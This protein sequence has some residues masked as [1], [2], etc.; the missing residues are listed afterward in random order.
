MAVV[1]AFSLLRIWILHVFLSHK[2]LC[3]TTCSIRL[4]QALEQN[5]VEACV[6]CDTEERN[7][8]IVLIAHHDDKSEL[9][10]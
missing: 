4:V 10:F 7:I 2:V 6:W 3:F 9:P 1:R 8:N 5:S